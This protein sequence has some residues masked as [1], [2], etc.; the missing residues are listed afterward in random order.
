VASKYEGNEPDRIRFKDRFQAVAISVAVAL[1]KTRVVCA[2][3][4]Q[5]TV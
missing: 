5:T 2:S 1:G 3:T 4:R